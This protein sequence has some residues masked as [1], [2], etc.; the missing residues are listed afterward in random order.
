MRYSGECAHVRAQ[1]QEFQGRSEHLIGIGH[2]FC[3][4][5]PFACQGSR[6]R[7]ILIDHGVA[8][9]PAIVLVSHLFSELVLQPVGRPRLPFRDVHDQRTLQREESPAIRLVA[10]FHPIVPGPPGIHFRKS[11]VKQL[12]LG[13]L[14]I[15]ANPVHLLLEFWAFLRAVVEILHVSEPADFKHGERQPRHD[16]VATALFEFR[17]E[18]GSPVAALKFHAVHEE[19]SQML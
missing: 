10:R 14:E 7:D 15:K 12:C 1:L 19:S 11:F 8:S 17:S 6:R 13:E 3:A 5:H 9:S 4:D 18:I 16:V 2:L